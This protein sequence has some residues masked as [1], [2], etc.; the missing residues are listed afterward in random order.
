MTT[1]TATCHNCGFPVA[2]GARFCQNCGVDVSQEQAMVP[3]MSVA[4]L[5]SRRSVTAV[6]LELLR[7]E[8]LGEYEILGEL[9]RG[10]MATV[11][12]A[13]HIALDRKVAIK[14]LSPSLVDEGLA[15]RFRREARTAAS[16]NH[17]HIIPIYGVYERSTLIYFVMK[18]VAGQSLDPI[19][20]NLGKFPVKMAQTVLAQAASALGYAHRRGVIHRDVK[21]ANIMLDEEGWVV[22]TDFGIAKAPSATGLT[23]T[24]VTVGTPAYMSPEQCLGKEVTGASDQYSLGVVAYELLTGRKPFTATTAMAMMY[25]HFNETPTPLRELRPDIPEDLETS[26]L[27]MLEKDPEKRW[28]RID[29]AFGTPVLAHDDPVRDQLVRFAQASPNATMAARISVPTSPVPPARRTST[30]LPVSASTTE[31]VLPVK[32]RGEDSPKDQAAPPP[33]AGGTATEVPPPVAEAPVPTDATQAGRGSDD[34]ATVSL[35][36][37]DSEVARPPARPSVTPGVGRKTTAKVLTPAPRRSRPLVWAAAALGVIAVGAVLL[38]RSHKEAGLRPPPATADTTSPAPAGG[39]AARG[40]SGKPGPELTGGRPAGTD[41]SKSSTATGPQK[42]AAIARLEIPQ[43]S[44]ILDV[45][46]SAALGVRLL[47][48]DGTTLADRGSVTWSSSA[49]AIAVVDASGTIRGVAVGRATIT[50]RLEGRKATVAV[51]VRPAPA[52]PSAEVAVASIRLQPETASVPVGQAVTLTAILLDAKGKVLGARPLTWISTDSA[53]AAVTQSGTVSGRSPGS[54]RIV[55]R[56]EGATGTAEITVLPEPVANVKISGAPGE[57]LKPGEV[58]DLTATAYSAGGAALPGRK[59]IWSSSDESVA[60]VANGKVSA[61]AAG[62]ATIAASIEGQNSTVSVKVSAP[63]ERAPAEPD[64]R[65]A[66]PEITRLIQGFVDALNSRDMKQVRA[67]YPG[68]T[69]KEESNWKNL[70]QNRDVSKFQ[71]TLAENGPAKVSGS[72]LEAPI[73]LQLNWTISGLGNSGD[74]KYTAFFA[75]E[76][77][78][79]RLMQL[80][81]R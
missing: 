27:R 35:P 5:A 38:T 39:A 68:M 50:A 71:A 80:T 33:E 24:G 46:K 34:A 65:A 70:L 76:G 8:T 63:V 52:Q 44:Q 4:A 43:G 48:A 60:A 36:S 78:E 72:G 15:E 58:V 21:P 6:S 79:W 47:G 45:G 54:A 51:T 62:S 30:R 73:R 22:V 25:A 75:Q 55:A 53:S 49:P 29:D 74:Q 10:G 11:Y 1:E 12:L 64:P 20:K 14:V 9:G 59:A 61:R 66:Q 57:A 7:E 19:L 26:I 28:P 56:V 40:D 31:P 3:T 81:P 42:P 41:T 2:S 37:H 32:T 69:G 18:F 16:L 23:L 77:G 67:A 13:H 17:P